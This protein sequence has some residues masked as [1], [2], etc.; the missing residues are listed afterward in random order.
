M[1]SLILILLLLL[2][3]PIVMRRPIWGAIIYMAANIIRPEMLF[4]GGDSGSFVF[5]FY[6]VLT[7]VATFCKGKFSF[8]EARLREFFLMCWLAIGVYLSMWFSSFPP[9]TSAGYYALELVK[10]FS[11]CIIIAMNIENI[12]EIARMQAIFVGCFTFMG[13]WG[14][15][16]YLHGNIRVEG[17]GG[18]AWGDSNFV[19]G[20]FVMILPVALSKAYSALTRSCFWVWLGSAVII[21]VLIICTNS[22]GGALGMVACLITFGLFTRQG[23]KMLKV[24]VV[25]ALAAMPIATATYLDRMKTMQV[26]DTENLEGSARSRLILWQAGLMVFSDNPLFGTGFMTYPEAKMAYEG[27]FSYLEDDFRAMVF[28]KENKKVT[29]NTY[30]QLLSDCG[31]FGA[32]PFILLLFPCTFKGFAYR[33][34][35]RTAEPEKTRSLQLAGGIAAGLTGYMVCLFFMNGLITY[36]MYFQIVLLSILHRKQ[37][38]VTPPVM[39]DRELM[40]A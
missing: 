20:M 22:R 26:S 16:Q 34:E 23:F 32:L 10:T 14:I 37:S 38:I 19:A 12:N 17:L 30:I 33:R 7:T 3:I 2:S 9:L 11:F 21:A 6:Y 18:D 35:L 27:H 25:I 13:I 29:H 8:K 4:W 36:F 15:V 1:R 28:R 24:L 40:H 5:V 39:S 31:I